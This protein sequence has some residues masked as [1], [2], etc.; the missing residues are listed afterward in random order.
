MMFSF[1]ESMMFSFSPGAI[2]Q[3]LAAT[4]T[5][6]ARQSDEGSQP[7]AEEGEMKA[8]PDGT[9]SAT[10]DGSHLAKRVATGHS[11]TTKHTY[12]LQEARDKARSLEACGDE[13]E[14][15][16]CALVCFT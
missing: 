3:D 14:S 13:D 8:I 9:A 15:H 11:E 1:S 12:E 16:Y 4:T 5:P 6:E 2:C 10:G 7:D